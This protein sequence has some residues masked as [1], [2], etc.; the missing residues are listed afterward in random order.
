M[1]GPGALKYKNGKT[2]MGEWKNGE[3]FGKGIITFEGERY[4]GG[5]KDGEYSGEGALVYKDGK[6]YYG[7]WL[8]NKRHGKGKLT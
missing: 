3:F 2:L 6:K 5:V 7:S 8:K 4:E 1:Q